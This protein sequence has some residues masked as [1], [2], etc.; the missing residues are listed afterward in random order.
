MEPEIN[1]WQDAWEHEARQTRSAYQNFTEAELIQKVEQ[2]QTD[3]FYQIWSV[4]GEKGTRKN[5]ALPMWQYLKDHPGEKYMLDRYHCTAAL[6]KILKINNKEHEE[7]EKQVKWDHDGEEA[8]QE[9]LKKLKKIIK[10]LGKPTGVHLLFAVIE[11]NRKHKII[12]R[13][14]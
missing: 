4:L 11:T 6:F 10:S 12:H 14:L 8:R 3:M 5:A 1:N 2:N 9:A 13:G 7:L